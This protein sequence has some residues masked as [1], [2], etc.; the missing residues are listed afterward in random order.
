MTTLTETFHAAGFLVSEAPGSRSRSA[1]VVAS[2]AAVAAGTVIGR[3]TATSVAQSFSGTGVG[4]L[5]PD[6]STP[7]LAGVQE[8][9][10]RIVCTEPASNAGR[11][12]VY[13]PQ[14]V[15]LGGHTVAGSAFSNQIKF[16]IADGGTDFV[17][18]DQFTIY[19]KA[20][21]I[22]AGGSNTGNGTATLYQ[23]TEGVQI[24][25]YTL[26]CT[27]TASNAG[28][29]SVVAP[30]ATSLGALTVG[31]RYTGGGLDL[32]IADGSSDFI[33][34]DTF[35]IAVTR[36]KVKAWDPANTDGSGTAFGVLWA[37]AAS[38]SADVKGAAI[39]RDAEVNKSELVWKSGLTEAQKVTGLAQLAAA[40]IIGR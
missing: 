12:E 19:V 24:G 14:G 4:I 10:Y 3:I 6:G 13:D 25:T 30:D 35:T 40:G 16:T 20:G 22:T 33:V 15:H 34:G 39:V 37:D 36:G 29:F 9:A 23:T 21:T 38:A 31:T 28:T 26:T 2:G 1:V 7:V 8:G 18:G 11:F 27:A 32:L 17:A 5:T